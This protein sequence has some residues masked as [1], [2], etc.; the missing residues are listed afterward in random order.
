MAN[1]ERAFGVTNIKHRIPLV[2]DLDVFNY[3]AWRELFLTH[4]LTFD[5]LGHV[6]GTSV[7]TDDDDLAWKKRN[8]LVKLWIYGTLAP[9]LFKSSFKTG[10]S[11]RDIWLRR[12]NQ[13]RNNKESRVI[14][15]DNDL[16]TKEIGDQSIHEYSQSL[17]SIADLLENVKAPVSDKILVM[18]MLSGLNEEFDHIINV[19]K[20][21]KPFP[22]FEESRNML[23]LEETR[24]KKPI[25]GSSSH[26]NA[27]SSSS[28]LVATV[29]HNKSADIN[30]RQQHNNR[31]NRRGGRGRGRY[32]YNQ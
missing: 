8:G 13:F 25:K 14:Q 5:L 4:C 27:A 24:L 17:I 16:R 15:L 20:H 29:P 7:P 11:A 23:E 9:P 2:L 6:D 12:E 18:Y 22:T 26:S 1:I 31:G 3:D 32:N 30:Q 21:Q 19:I 10:G 28:A